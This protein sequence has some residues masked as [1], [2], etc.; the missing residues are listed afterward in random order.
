MELCHLTAVALALTAVLQDL[1]RGM[2]PNAFTVSSAAAGL[3]FSMLIHGVVG[4]AWITFG[5]LALGLGL[6]LPLFL[7]GGMGGGDVKLLACIGA[8]VGPLRVFS[9]FVY[10]SLIGGLACLYLLIRSNRL[11]ALNR[12]GADVSLLVGVRARLE[13]KKD[14]LTISYSLPIAVG[15]ILA[16]FLGDFL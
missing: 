12:V 15:T 11:S 1:T 4:G 16:T 10:G 14:S 3:I 8:W 2:I 5:G 7:L 13:P 9:I 6:L